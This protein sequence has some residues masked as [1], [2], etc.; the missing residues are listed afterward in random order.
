M[1]GRIA[2]S[3]LQQREQ[4]TFHISDDGH[5]STALQ[6]LRWCEYFATRCGKPGDGVVDILNRHGNN[7]LRDITAIIQCHC[8]DHAANQSAFMADELVG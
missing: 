6:V 2:I 1:I 5:S 8:V 4:C 7:P 3:R